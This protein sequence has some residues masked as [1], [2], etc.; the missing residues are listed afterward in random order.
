[1]TDRKLSDEEKRERLAKIT[2]D[3]GVETFTFPL[4]NWDKDSPQVQGMRRY[5]ASS[6]GCPIEA[7]EVVWDCTIGEGE[8]K[9]PWPSYHLAKGWKIVEI[10]EHPEPNIAT[11]RR[12]AVRQTEGEP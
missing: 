3:P 7:V 6:W 11:Y 9:R 4:P 5:F 10:V 1:M 8:E 2:K 12:Q